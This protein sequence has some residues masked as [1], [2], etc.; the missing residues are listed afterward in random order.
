MDNEAS[1][2]DGGAN[3]SADETA[4]SI[5]GLSRKRKL[6]KPFKPPTRRAPP[7]GPSP[8]SSPATRDRDRDAENVLSRG[9][10]Y[11]PRLGQ[12]LQTQTSYTGFGNVASL[13]EQEDEEAEDEGDRNQENN[14]VGTLDP[15]SA[16]AETRDQDTQDATDYRRQE[17]PLHTRP[18][19][20]VDTQRPIDHIAHAHPATIAGLLNAPENAG[21]Q[22]P[23]GNLECLRDVHLHAPNTG[24]GRSREAWLSPDRVESGGREESG[25]TRGPIKKDDILGKAKKGL[26]EEVSGV[27]TGTWMQDERGSYTTR[28]TR[29]TQDIL[30]LFG[31]DDESSTQAIQAGVAEESESNLESR[32]YSE[33]HSS[34]EEIAM[35]LVPGAKGGAA[36]ARPAQGMDRE[37][38][39]FRLRDKPEPS[40]A[41]ITSNRAPPSWTCGVCGVGGS[42]SSISCLVCGVPRARN[43]VGDEND[44]GDPEE[45]DEP[46]PGEVALG[47]DGD[48]GDPSRRHRVE[49]IPP[50]EGGRRGVVEMG[51]RPSDIDALP[52]RRGGSSGNFGSCDNSFASGTHYPRQEHGARMEMDVGSSS[53]NEG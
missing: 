51:I 8:A 34:G 42:P 31:G 24:H 19:S 39:R 17:H 43:D 25:S 45:K 15:L 32:V 35:A 9:R 20:T 5:A 44:R 30:S 18:Q 33:C 52:P 21:T 47:G 12:G 48:V 50:K 46:L 28:S 29:S 13:W 53:D 2:A 49:T 14:V 37:A 7:V 40:T 10:Q 36:E 22:V 16:V 23:P 6:L 27:G 26:N 1:I 3:G 41:P 11:A 4:S 38:Q